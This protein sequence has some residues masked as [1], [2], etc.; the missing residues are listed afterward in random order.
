M[1]ESTIDESGASALCAEAFA[2]YVQAQE[3][4]QTDVARQM[5]R[6]HPGLAEEVA[7]FY[8]QCARLPR[9]WESSVHSYDG[10]TIGDFEL[11]HELGRG[12]E[13]VVYKARQ[14]S[15]QRVVAV[16]VM[17]HE[18]FAQTR[19]IERFRRDS[20]LLASLHHPN[21]VQIFYAGEADT[22]PYFA[23]ELMAAGSLKQKLADGWLPTPKQAA[24]LVHDLAEAVQAAHDQGIVHRDL[25]PANILLHADGTPKIVDYGLAKKLDA[26]ESMTQP[27]AIVGTASYMSPEQA[28][29]ERAERASDVYG[30]GAILYELLTGRP[31]FVGVSLDETL[32][33]VKYKDPLPIRKFSPTVPRDLE[34]ICLKCLEKDP[35]KR[36]R[37]AADLAT[38]LRS[39]SR[40]EPIKARLPGMTE[41][42]AR[43]IVRERFG[44]NIVPWGQ[45]QRIA[46][47]L[48]FTGF[49]A[50]G[51]CVLLELSDDVFWAV[52]L[53][54]LFSVAFS[55]WLVLRRC[56][57][58]RGDRQGVI[59]SLVNIAGPVLVPLLNPPLEGVD[60]MAYRLSLFP[61]IGLVYGIV[62]IL[63]GALYWGGYYVTG[64]TCIVICFGMRF[65]PMASPFILA[66][67]IGASLIS[68]GWYLLRVGRATGR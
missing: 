60:P 5:L 27:G 59:F 32:R 47:V 61:L 39:F 21:I 25:K 23:M 26:G 19:E 54:N 48:L 42:V 40:G 15:L 11:L 2:A 28:R 1:T 51:V 18:R 38:D 56:R 53:T 17:R 22:G 52:F 66:V 6:D 10:Q 55:H 30:L 31:P 12:G 29:G 35:Q 68:L 41:R 16:K 46:G 43:V 62:A 36:F 34:V 57:L 3:N 14:K 49:S 33:Q 8:A 44:A 9:P 4:G 64:V 63:Q 20:T 24:G 37:S 67:L 7:T 65:V 45:A 50:T 58:G 13:G